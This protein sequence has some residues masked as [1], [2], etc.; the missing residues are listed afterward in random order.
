MLTPPPPEYATALNTVHL[1]QVY[2]LSR[3]IIVASSLI[4]YLIGRKS[5]TICTGTRNLDFIKFCLS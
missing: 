5:T 4:V 1:E 2:G 3:P